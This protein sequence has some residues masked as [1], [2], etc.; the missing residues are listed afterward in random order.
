LQRS[1]IS[2]ALRHDVTYHWKSVVSGIA[3]ALGWF[4][5]IPALI[6]MLVV[7][8]GLWSTPLGDPPEVS[9]RSTRPS[10]L[11]PPVITPGNTEVEKGS[12][13]IVTARFDGALPDEV[14][15]LQEP[16][17]NSESSEP[18]QI[19]MRQ[20]L[21]DPV[22]AAYLYG[23]DEATQYRVEYDQETTE[24]YRIDVFEYPTL[25]RADAKIEY[26]RYSGQ[27]PKTVVDTRR[28]T[29]P[30]GSSLT[31]QLHL[32]KEVVNA[33]L[34]PEESEEAFAD[35][36]PLELVPSE[37]NPKLVE[38]TLSVYETATWKL[39]LEDAEGRSNN[40]DVTL[41]VKVLPNRET[42]IQ[43]TAGGDSQ[44]SPIEEFDVAAKLRDDFAVTSA[45][46]GYQFAGG[47]IVEVESELKQG[48][49]KEVVLSEMIDFEALGAE[50]RQLLSYYVWAEDKDTSGEKR[51]TV[52]DMYFAEVRYF[53]EIFRQGQQQSAS[54][55]QQQQ[56][57][58]QQG[59]QGGNEQTEKLLELQKQIVVGTWNVLK[60]ARGDELP[61]RV[62]PDII[63]LSDSQQ[64]AIG[65][66]DERAQ[67][68]EGQEA[69]PDMA[70]ILE[71]T[72]GFMEE[73]E[74]KLSA[75][76][77]SQAKDDLQKALGREQAAYQELL[78]LQAREFEISRQQQQQQ[79]QQQSQRSQNRQQ[80]ID[81]LQMQNQQNDYETERQAQEQQDQG[82]DEQAELRQVISRLRELAAR[83]EDINEQLRELEAALQAAETPEE[84]QELQ[85]QL[86]RLREQQQQMLQD[87]DEL[88]ERIE[89]SEN[90]ALQETQEQ[91]QQTRENLQQS[92]ES[93]R[94]DNT[95]QALASGT[96]AE[97]ELKDMQDEVRQQAANQFAETV[98]N[99]KNDAADLEQRQK[100]IVEQM[101]GKEEEQE[102][103]GL[104]SKEPDEGDL[105]EQLR[106]QQEELGDLLEE[107][108]QTVVDAEE[109]EPLLAQK[110]YDSY[111]RTKQER[112]EERLDV[113]EQLLDGNLQQDAQNLAEQSIDDFTN[114]REDIDEAAE[115]VLGSEVD[116]LRRAVNQLDQLNN[117]LDAEIADATGRPRRGSEAESPESQAATEDRNSQQQNP[118]ATGGS[119]ESEEQQ[120][121]EQEPGQQ[122]RGQGNGERP[123]NEEQGP[124]EQQPRDG[125]QQPR[126]VQQQPRD[127]QQQPRDG[128][129]QPQDGQQQPRDGQQ[130]PR[131][132]QQQPRDGQQ[133]PRDGQQ[134]PRDGQQQ[135]QGQQPQ[136]GQPRQGQPRGQEP[137]PNE[138][139][140]IRN[141][142][143]NA[144]PLGDP[145]N[146]WNGGNPR[147]LTGEEFEQ[148]SDRLRDVE[149][150]VSDPELRWEATQIRQAAREI[151]R[152]YR[153]H[154]ADPK[155]AEVEDLV[156]KPLRNLQRKV[157]EELLRK[158]AEKTEIVP[159]DR[160][161]VPGEFSK[162]VREYYEN[163]GIGQ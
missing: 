34:V 88:Q 110:L 89:S 51:R 14:W 122:Q 4:A 60:S 68:G 2:E 146:N 113:T 64:Q 58:Q 42:K 101:E 121:G 163:L 92:S 131:D 65:L 69:S 56:Q 158:A 156:A 77:S 27:D 108:E 38:A 128:Q 62:S 48:K 132:G 115:A 130:Q 136:D 6:F 91:M 140:G 153:K 127:G 36:S 57:Q 96:R 119:S 157:S 116:A 147:P 99:M 117:E 71:A 100:D 20:S 83:Q 3:I 18:L 145:F 54:E 78:R 98:Q 112:A 17:E 15:L 37:S 134:Q 85:E 155:W 11:V 44:V 59:Q 39:K 31:W 114:L 90:E 73:A 29:V 55:Q 159:I 160:D 21:K 123:E 40:I 105:G 118:N 32:N 72:R 93:L 24:S 30:I 80:Q 162:S 23:I 126:D 86:E 49:G 81:Q 75:A 43:L 53:E 142:Q 125:Q 50:P 102:T 76:A 151:R 46:I 135:P 41:R 22:F 120:P 137:N 61:G 103:G 28:V 70:E 13:L 95:S 45:G 63:V 104:R 7:G 67:S 107:M 33:E 143:D 26:P 35:P 150:L 12:S 8:F 47:D 94:Q 16:A 25:V 124:G 139:P 5:N 161:P 129:Q 133:Q 9:K 52:S 19:A 106:R 74:D 154:A 138:Q 84:Q 152:D 66:L 87:A 10:T 79:Q 97:Q 109:A 141:F 149:E 111:R 148:W 82:N 1:V 144:N